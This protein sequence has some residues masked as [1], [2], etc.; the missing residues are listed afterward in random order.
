M[1]T[2]SPVDRINSYGVRPVDSFNV[3]YGC[4]SG[5]VTN[6]DS[7][8]YILFVS[9]F[10]VVLPWYTDLDRVLGIVFLTHNDA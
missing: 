10:V 4:K 6:R 3:R 2:G 5:D 8:P 7:V 1:Y 9:N